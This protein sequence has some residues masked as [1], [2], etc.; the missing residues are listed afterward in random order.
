M[1]DFSHRVYCVYSI[2][3]GYSLSAQC[4]CKTNTLLLQYR[5]NQ[6]CHAQSFSLPVFFFLLLD[7]EECEEGNVADMEDG[8]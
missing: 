1:I 7:N 3:S 2:L 4:Q 8:E 6:T 5:S